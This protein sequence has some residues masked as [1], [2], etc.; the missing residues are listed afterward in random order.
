MTLAEALNTLK[1]KDEMLKFSMQQIEELQSMVAIKDR[2][3]NG[4]V[5]DIEALKGGDLKAGTQSVPQLQRQATKDLEDVGV[6]DDA[7][8]IPSFEMIHKVTNYEMKI[9]NA[10]PSKTLNSV[11][12]VEASKKADGEN[13]LETR[14]TTTPS[15]PLSPIGP[16][17]LTAASSEEAAKDPPTP[18]SSSP[19][20]PKVELVDDLD[21]ELRQSSQS[22]RSSRR[23]IRAS[24]TAGADDS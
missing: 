17:S 13:L 16:S 20:A 10:I 15:S 5:R 1:L 6:E 9:S 23:I 19:T 18:Q 21:V 4:L 22:E 24:R 3:I 14:K 12:G 7:A 2:I 11:G 8:K